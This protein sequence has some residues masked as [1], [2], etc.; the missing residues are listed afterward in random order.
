MA[1]HDSA[2]ASDTLT[3]AERAA[4]DSVPTGLYIGGA[5]RGTTHRMPVHDPSTGEVITTVADAHPGDGRAAL[6]AAVDAQR[7]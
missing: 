7:P 3:R 6:D 2:H 4:V 1:D 5:W